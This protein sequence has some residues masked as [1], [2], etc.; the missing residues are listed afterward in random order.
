MSFG[1]WLN[2]IF[3]SLPA[4]SKNDAQ[5]KKGKKRLKIIIFIKEFL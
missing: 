2:T 4:A 3:T 1:F 5:F